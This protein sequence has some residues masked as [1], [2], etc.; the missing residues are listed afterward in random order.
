VS[1]IDT[2]EEVGCAMKE[3]SAID[4]SEHVGREEGRYRDGESRLG[5]APDAD[6]RQ[7]QL[8]RLANASNGAGLALLMAGRPED[9]HPWFSRAAERYRE[10]FEDAPPESWGRPV[11][12]LKARVLSGDW[13][14]AG[15]DGRWA[16]EIG[17]AEAT[18]PIGRYAAALACLVLEDYDRA[19]VHADE[20]R[21]H[22]GFP[23]DVGDALAFIAAEDVVGY[24]A[25]VEA[26]LAS[27]EA[28]D[29][30]LEDIPVADTVLVLQALA[31]RRTMAAE[32]DS[33]LLPG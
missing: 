20:L 31:D 16:L 6:S 19:R 8:T 30:F 26:V 32:L 29:E 2:G 17:A 24:I 27:F 11:G 5:D 23:T 3:A 14:A 22:E 9:A 18:S 4:W 28:R 21:T 10:S 1:R 13:T 33:P 25:A 15:G 7:R 12:A